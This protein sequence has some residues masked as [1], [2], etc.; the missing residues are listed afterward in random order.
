MSAYLEEGD[1][2]ARFSHIDDTSTEARPIC[3]DGGGRSF[4]LEPSIAFGDR[5]FL[6]LILR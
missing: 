2:L 4:D 1:G 6:A 5:Y 3:F